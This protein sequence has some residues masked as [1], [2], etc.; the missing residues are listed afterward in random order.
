MKKSTVFI[1]SLTLFCFVISSEVVSSNTSFNASPGDSSLLIGDGSVGRLLIN[2]DASKLNQIFSSELICIISPKNQIDSKRYHIKDVPDGKPVLEVETLCADIC[3]VSRI[4]ILSGIYKTISGIGVGSLFSQLKI[5][6][7]LKTIT[8]GEKN[9]LLV[10][11][12][13]LKDLAFVFKSSEKIKAG[14]VYGPDVLND[15]D[16]IDHIILF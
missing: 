14:E 7:S 11:V 16:K 5:N 8:G 1:I 6:Y 12:K 4:K 2:M 10:Y 3:L 9:T 13:E 15:S